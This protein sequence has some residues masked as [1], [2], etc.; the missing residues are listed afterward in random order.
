MPYSNSTTNE[1]EIDFIEH[2]WTQKW[3]NKPI[4]CVAG[5]GGYST[6]SLGATGKNFSKNAYLP[7][8]HSL[9]KT[10]ESLGCSAE[11]IETFSGLD[12]IIHAWKKN[13][14]PLFIETNFNKNDY[15]NNAKD[16][17]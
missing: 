11:K 5:N 12:N 15:I 2:F 10:V 3:K 17:K 9:C 7:Q 1:K 8:Y 14:S 13:P 4:V 16:L 6:I